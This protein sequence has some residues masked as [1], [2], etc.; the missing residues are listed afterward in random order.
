MARRGS[1]HELGGELVC[2]AS[3]GSRH[4]QMELESRCSAGTIEWSFQ[5]QLAAVIWLREGFQE[6]QLD[7][8]GQY[9]VAT[10]PNDGALCFVPAEMSVAGEFTVDPV[11]R[12]ALVFLDP[13]L[14]SRRGVVLPSEPMIA[15]ENEAM[16]SGLREL[17]ELFGQRTELLTLSLEGWAM[18]SV[19]RLSLG[20]CTV[21]RR[22]GSKGGLPQSI[23]IDELA[24][25]AGFSRRHFIRAF[26]NSVG[27]T[28]H[29]YVS[30]LRIE[31]ARRRLIESEQSVTSIA[32]ECGFTQAPHFSSNFRRA[33]GMSPSEFRNRY[34]V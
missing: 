23:T 12:Y 27:K 7:V 29:R 9:V 34:R 8:A 14:R 13:A 21:D 24:R 5:Q 19:A 25:V 17:A 3:A 26:Q 33:V 10:I 30:A 20:A 16:I 15:F 31:E 11:C 4:I 22:P 2:S 32:R 1:H 6:L 18:Q 28:P